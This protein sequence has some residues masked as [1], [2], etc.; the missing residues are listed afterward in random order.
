V[1]KHIAEPPPAPSDVAPQVPRWLSDVI[2]RCLAKKPGDRF[3][4]AQAV[5][6]AIATGRGAADRMPSRAISAQ[7]AI[8]AVGAIGSGAK[9]EVVES[10][11][12]SSA[13]TRPPEATVPV[14]AGR[15][16]RRGRPG[17]GVR[18]AA[19]IALPLVALAAAG[20]WLVVPRLVFHNRLA[21][22]VALGAG[23]RE[24]VVPPGKRARVWLPR[25]RAL[26]VT[27]AVVQPRA[28][29]GTPLG[30]PVADTVPIERPRGSVRLAARAE[31][32]GRPYFAPLITNLTG[33]PLR[34]IV[35]W[36]LQGA[37][38]CACTVPPGA[39]RQAIGYYPL[40]ANSTVRVEDVQGRGAAFQNLGAQ[41]DRESG[42]VRLQFSV[43]DLR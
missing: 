23:G 27:W 18:R 42:V 7:R 41:V 13:R 6:E 12:R 40:F 25:G 37:M 33:R 4:T 36:R 21:A 3:P 34:V 31:P 19:A 39:E 20:A 32:R 15:G 29:D 26:A 10:G 11:A 1:G 43:G 35:N 17:R 24:R 22:P 8:A 30:V 5:L 16:G 28:P 14:G 9:T 38:P 2:V